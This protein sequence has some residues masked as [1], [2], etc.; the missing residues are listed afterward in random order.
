VGYVIGVIAAIAL[1]LCVLALQVLIAP[2]V[3]VAALAASSGFGLFQVGRWS[4]RVLRVRHHGGPSA[5]LEP[6]DPV[7]AYLPYPVR[8]AWLDLATVVRRSAADTAKAVYQLY[9][10]AWLAL[11]EDGRGWAL[12]GFPTIL[13]LLAGTVL[14]GLPLLVG[15]AVASLAQVVVA[16]GWAVMWLAVV[17]TLG[18]LEVALRAVR[19]VV[20]ACPHPGCYHRF[21]L[22]EYDCSG[23]D[24]DRVH[25]GLI[26]GRNGAWRHACACGASLPTLVLF[27]RFRLTARCPRCHRPLPRRAGR[28]RIEHVPIVGGPDAGKTTFLCLAIGAIRAA[29]TGNRGSVEFPDH[30]AEAVW[31]GSWAVL[32]GGNRLD[33]TPVQPPA[34]VMLDIQPRDSNGRILYMFDP[35]GEYYDSTEMVDTQRYLDHAEV[36]LLVVDPLAIP[37]VWHA[38]TDRDRQAVADLSAPNQEQVTREHP[39]DIVD[40]LTAVLRTRS[41]GGRLRRLLLVVSKCDVLKDTSV[42]QALGVDRERDGYHVRDWLAEVGWGNGIRSVELSVGEV[43]YLASGLTIGDGALAGALG[44]LTGAGWDGTRSGW[45]RRLAR[46]PLRQPR[47]R[48]WQSTSRPGRIPRGHVVGRV[49]MLAGSVPLGVV[50]A[51]TVTGLLMAWLFSLY[52]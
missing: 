10:R 32:R 30:R 36:A 39:G 46:R 8:Q 28:I 21:G 26:P 33:K 43:R 48:P 19:R 24:C 25:R 41:D 27:G 29:V 47:G 11:P 40:R 34:A 4:W 22:P 51:V 2:I 17:G 35:A 42:G 23:Q 31:S 13:A 7:L 52:A 9:K 49:V 3:I 45:V 14:A 44:W 5:D 50:A 37:G 12:V 6:V 1:L 15:A 38:F 20:V 18:S 16:A